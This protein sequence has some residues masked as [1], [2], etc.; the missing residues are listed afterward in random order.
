M[1]SK[2][3][4]FKGLSYTISLS[5][6]VRRFRS[7]ISDFQSGRFFRI[8]GNWIVVSTQGYWV[9]FQDIGLMDIYFMADNKTKLIDTG[10]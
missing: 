5:K 3:W 10:F 8:T 2:D 6:V 7:G 4:T 9:A 1:A